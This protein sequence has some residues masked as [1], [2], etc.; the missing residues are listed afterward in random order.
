[1]LLLL[2]CPWG[3][4]GLMNK[5][6]H[7]DRGTRLCL[8]PQGS[9]SPH[10]GPGQILPCHLLLY[11]FGVFL[12][13]SPQSNG[14]ATPLLAMGSPWRAGPILA[15]STLSLGIAVLARASTLT[16]RIHQPLL[17]T[18]SLTGTDR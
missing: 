2:V 16:P 5:A 7:G 13:L 1:M 17:H 14:G 11:E 3:N 8:A 6:A 18:G 4:V 9:Q 15:A 12:H 10:M